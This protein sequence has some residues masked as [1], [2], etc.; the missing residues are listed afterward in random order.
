MAYEFARSLRKTGW[1]PSD[2]TYARSLWVERD[3]RN[4]PLLAYLIA[5]FTAGYHLEAKPNANEVAA[6]RTIL[7]VKSLANSLA[8]NPGAPLPG[9]TAA[10]TARLE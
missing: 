6:V 4:S 10:K 7:Q 1:Q 2:E 8:E 3:F 9:G 5:G